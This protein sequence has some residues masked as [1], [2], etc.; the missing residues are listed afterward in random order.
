MDLNRSRIIFSHEKV[1]E[2]SPKLGL[3][4]PFRRP[5]RILPGEVVWV[6][7]TGDHHGDVTNFLLVNVVEKT[8]MVQLSGADHVFLHRG[9]TG[10]LHI[11][12]VL[13]SVEESFSQRLHFSSE[14][15]RNHDYP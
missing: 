2:N 11:I 4:N 1:I 12:L 9:Q 15:S 3:S 7:Q 10:D 14:S 6:A 13:S 5:R 8:A